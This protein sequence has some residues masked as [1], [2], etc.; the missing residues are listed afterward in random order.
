MSCAS[1]VRYALR[2]SNVKKKN[3]RFVVLFG[4]MAQSKTTGKY[5]DYDIAI[6][7][8]KESGSKQHLAALETY[9][10]VFEG[11]LLTGDVWTTS[12]FR[13]AFLQEYDSEFL[14]RKKQIGK[15]KLLYGDRNAFVALRRK[16]LKREWTPKAQ[17]EVIKPAYINMLEYYC[18]M[19]NAA[20][21]QNHLGFY[22]ASY[23]VAHNSMKVVAGINEINLDS[24]NSLYDQIL[25]QA[26]THPPDFEQD[27]IIIS[28]FKSGINR[29]ESETL[30]ATRRLLQW[31]R[32]YLSSSKSWKPSIDEEF[33]RI[34]EL[35]F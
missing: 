2:L 27:F 13:S 14:W 15:A 26:R 19:R 5:S 31:T 23:V 20:L 24:E 3:V 12:S 33:T 35:P 30:A 4:S 16:A 7:V 10:G 11:K 6:V 17:L 22:L 1:L 29:S 25:K 28:G 9:E 18:K 21:A 8:D 32:D 34:L